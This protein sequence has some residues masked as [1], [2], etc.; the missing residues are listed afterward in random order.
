MCCGAIGLLSNIHI[1]G[2][3]LRDFMSLPPM[4]TLW[5]AA[6]DMPNLILQ[7]IKL[8]EEYIELH[9]LH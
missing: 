9:M 4:G 1:R 7:L 2:H 8:F 3:G 6:A 5:T